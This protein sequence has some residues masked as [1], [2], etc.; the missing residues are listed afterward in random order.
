MT[1]TPQSQSTIVMEN[2]KAYRAIKTRLLA[3]I[4]TKWAVGTKIPPI[5]MLAAQIGAG[6]TNTHKAIKE[7]V[8]EGL[9]A[10]RA[11]QGT[12]VLDAMANLE[13]SPSSPQSLAREPARAVAGS[14]IAIVAAPK[15]LEGF[16]QIVVESAQEVFA[17]AGCHV[18]RISFKPEHR[19]DVNLHD[20][21]ISAHLVLNWD[22]KTPIQVQPG[23]PLVCL[24]TTAYVR[25]LG[26]SGYDIV[27]A[28]SEQGG[29]LAGEHLRTLAFKSVCFIGVKTTSR[30]YD[31]TSALRLE[32][33]EAG[34]GACVPPEFQLDAEFYTTTAGASIVRQFLA[35][36]P[37][38][39][40][41]FCASDD[42]AVGFVHGALAHGMQPG[43][44]YALV[45]FDGQ[46]RGRHLPTGELTTAAIPADLMGRSAANFLITRMAYP[47]LPVRR[48]QLGCTLYRGNTTPPS[49]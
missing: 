4:G 39:Q 43:K 20:P 1:Q 33:F 48:L 26:A 46:Q 34:W 31:H 27:M 24:S 45:G 47:D 22:E 42:I 11:G 7:L 35:L 12:F 9:L 29:Y 6:Q 10:S 25:I 38:P 19:A 2:A 37:R 5:K 16:L 21:A 44:D 28:D 13:H 41:I 40:A 15:V 17:S 32:G 8:A 23:N 18:T 3:M 49:A 30:R 14:T 36:K